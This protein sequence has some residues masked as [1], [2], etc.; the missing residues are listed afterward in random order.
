MG[1][2]IWVSDTSGPGYLLSTL[3]RYHQA[4]R[5]PIVQPYLGPDREVYC[6]KA[7]AVNIHLLNVL[8]NQI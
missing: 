1:I 7:R 5:G 3:G 2:W 8:S 4:L 6:L